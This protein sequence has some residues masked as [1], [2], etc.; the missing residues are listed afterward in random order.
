[1]NSNQ[2]VCGEAENFRP[3]FR[4]GRERS[5]LGMRSKHQS[6]DQN[7]PT[8]THKTLKLHAQILRTNMTDAERKLWRRLRRRQMLGVQFY[9]QRPVGLYIIDFL[10]RVPKIVIEIDGGQHFEP[11]HKK[12]DRLRDLYLTSSG[13]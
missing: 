12:S 10:A 9:R 4:R 11:E 7:T 1:M 13:F 2:K 5:E 3:L 6:S 8:T